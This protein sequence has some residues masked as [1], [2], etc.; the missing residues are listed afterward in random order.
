M[1]NTCCLIDVVAYGY[2][3]QLIGGKP[4]IINYFNIVGDLKLENEYLG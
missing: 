2:L 4:Y 3:D 1:E